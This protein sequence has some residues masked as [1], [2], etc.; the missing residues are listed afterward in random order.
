[1][2]PYLAIIKDSFREAMASRV[3]WVLLGVITLVLALIAPLGVRGRLTTDFGGGEVRDPQDLVAKLRT[4]ADRP[5]NSPAKRI[6]S[7]WDANR[8]QKLI[9][10]Q[11]YQ[12]N[13]DGNSRKQGEFGEYMESRQTLFQGLKELLEK[14]DLYQPG[15][16]REESLP[17][18]AR[19]FIAKRDELTQEEQARLNR[20]LIQAAAPGQ[21]APRA[22]ES[23]AVAYLWMETTESLP[24]TKT[25]ADAFIKEV[26]VP[27]LMKYLV[28]VIG[29]FVAILV[30]SPVI[31][32]M[33][34]PGSINLLLSKPVQRSL[35][36][37]S[38][39]IGGCA[40]I[41]LNVGYLCMGLWLILGLRYGIWNRGMLLC[42]PIFLF[43]F[44]IYYAVSTLTGIVWKSAV[45]S[46]VICISLWLL[47]FIVGAIKVNVMEPFVVD[48]QRNVRVVDAGGSIIAVRESG[49]MYRWNAELK[50]W[51]QIHLPS[52][53]G[54]VRKTLGPFYHA[55]SDQL[56]IGE[57]WN[58]PFGLGTGRAI[59][60]VAGGNE[61]FQVKD[62]PAFP[63]DT[64]DL[65]VGSGGD[66]LAVAP[67]GIFR[68]QGQPAAAKNQ[69]KFLGMPLPFANRNEFQ[70]AMLD[71]ELTFPAPLKAAIDPVTGAV[72]VYSR[73]NV[74]LMSKDTKGNY[75]Q[76]ALRKLDGDEAQDA[77]IAI[78]GA[79]VFVARAD[80]QALFLS[81]EDLSVRAEKN[82][83]AGSQPRLVAASPDG[84]MFCALF[85]NRRL[86]LLDSET[87]DCRLAAVRG[88]GDISAFAFHGDRLLVADRITR[89]CDYQTADLTRQATYAPAMKTSQI[90]YYYV[91]SPIYYVLPK[92]GELD[93]T[94][95]YLLTGKETSDLG[96]F[97]GDLSQAR[98]NLHPWR[99]VWTSAIFVVVML[100]LSCVYIERHQF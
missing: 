82:L 29:V 59:F 56:L 15:V 37:L 92:P 64:G 66:V 47:C 94:V 26:I 30:T 50:D 28:G 76:K 75:V 87:S 44:T 19:D 1:M 6:W 51:E 98:D 8:Q 43:L 93:N 85:H 97:R 39:F 35:V 96:I 12:G 7:L 3:L 79:A 91:I 25:Q 57:S 62:G 73:G 88:Q 23:I 38:K 74:Y 22:A 45:V 40:F 36:F 84:K 55:P 83:E 61:G 63:A 77:A 27:I 48:L 100:L 68:L 72:A 52:G 78:G 41:L 71:K 10:F 14:E 46:V 54:G 89:V 99:P 18:E 2:R 58:P 31:P 90:V 80:D 13:Q 70:S 65:L 33:F 5:E 21:F 17:K 24:F 49:G 11:E 86:W 53:G 20:L 16:W 32:Q 34:E 42:I 81:T 67:G 60:H 9:K 69:I 4:A 95:Q